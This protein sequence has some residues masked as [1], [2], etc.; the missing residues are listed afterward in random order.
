LAI[1][2]DGDRYYPLEKLPQDMDR[3]AV[4]ER[5]GWIFARIRGTEFF[6]NPERAMKPVYD[7]LQHLEISPNGASPATPKKS[8][9]LADLVDRVISRAEELR[10]V[11][12][13]PEQNSTR[14]QVSSQAAGQV[15]VS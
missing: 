9:P 4:L 6:R 1:E 5:M 13:S 11:W 10:R 3:Q 2:C 7:K 14:R 12:G 15:T 8:Q